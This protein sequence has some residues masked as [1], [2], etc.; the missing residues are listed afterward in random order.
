MLH[1]WREAQNRQARNECVIQYHTSFSI[2]FC[3]K[4]KKEMKAQKNLFLLVIEE[5]RK[6]VLTSKRHVE[7]PFSDQNTQQIWMPAECPM[8]LNWQKYLKNI[9]NFHSKMKNLTV[10]TY[11]PFLQHGKYCPP[12]W[13]L[14]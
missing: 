13:D 9:Y 3:H 14:P 8:A 4:R 5:G 7:H 10:F 6:L 12:S 1:A 2:F 11:L